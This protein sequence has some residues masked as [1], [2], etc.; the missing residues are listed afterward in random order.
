MNT[1]KNLQIVRSQFF[2]DIF[3]LFGLIRISIGLS[4]LGYIANEHKWIAIQLHLT[5]HNIR[6][7]IWWAIMKVILNYSPLLIFNHT[8]LQHA[9]LARL[10]K[11]QFFPV[12]DNLKPFQLE[13]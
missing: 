12:G 7:A 11:W 4:V 10:Q 1:Y 13:R 8:S 6:S 2:T 3:G 5:I 9:Y